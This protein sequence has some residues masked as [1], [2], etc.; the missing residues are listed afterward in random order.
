M[1]E[2][3]V[4]IE[5]LPIAVEDLWALWTEPDKVTAWLAGTASIDLRLGGA[6]QLAGHLAGRTFH[7]PIG[8]LI[9]GLEEEY[10]LKVGWQLPSDLGS[11]VAGAVPPTTLGI[12]FQPLGPARTRIRLEHDGWRDGE[13]WAAARHWQSEAWTGVIDRLKKGDLPL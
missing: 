12:W 6:Y 1:A 2:P 7:G 8:G 13:E 9:T 10:V 3:L 4:L 5:E 11:A